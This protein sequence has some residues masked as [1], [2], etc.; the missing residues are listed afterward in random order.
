MT[1]ITFEHFEF[2]T[3]Q[4]MQ[5]Q[6]TKKQ[7]FPFI[8]FSFLTET[9]LWPWRCAAGKNLQK[10]IYTLVICMIQVLL[11]VVE[12]IF[13]KHIARTWMREMMKICWISFQRCV[14]DAKAG[15]GH[16]V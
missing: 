13:L 6:W 12:V 16:A 2:N 7:K 3:K 1:K 4:I 11:Y 5:L 8:F 14:R 10:I 9:N 15:K